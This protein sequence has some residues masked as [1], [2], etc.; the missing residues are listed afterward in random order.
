MK[1]DNIETS[2]KIIRFCIFILGTFIMGVA[3]NTFL[4]PNNIVVGGTTGLSI[5]TEKLFGWKPELFI[6][7]AGLFLLLICWIFLGFEKTKHNFIGTLLV[8]IMIALTLP[9]SEYLAAHI[10]IEDYIVFVC[11]GGSI[12][13]LGLG[14]IY[15]AGYATGGFDVIMMLINKYLKIHEGKAGVIANM[16]VVVIGLPV[17]GLTKMIYSTFTLLIQ[18]AVISKIT[19][20]ISESKLFF[21]YTRKL[22]LVRDSLIKEKDVG[23]TIIP[24]QG[25][26]SHYKGEMLMCVVSTRDYYRFRQTVLGIDPNAFFVINDCYEVNGGYKK[27]HLPFL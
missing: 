9:L 2:M 13:G 3:Y 18:G 17:L 20:G 10:N 19:V 22:D 16:L 11:L 23:F 24:T 15:K 5:I 21:V 14:L 1:K 26:Y 4:L 25:G 7:Y 12:Y 27:Q 6:L 8:P